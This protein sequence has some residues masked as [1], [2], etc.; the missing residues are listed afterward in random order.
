MRPGENPRGPVMWPEWREAVAGVRVEHVR[1]GYQGT[2]V[3]WPKTPKGRN[4]GYAVIL[5]DPLRPGAD[6]FTGKP[7][8][9]RVVAYAFDLCLAPE[10]RR[11]PN[12]KGA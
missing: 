2:F 8:R 4:P 9:G 12:L 7:Q 6:N 3:R 5:W 1:T 10:H 11:G